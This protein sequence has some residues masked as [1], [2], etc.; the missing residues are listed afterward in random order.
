V[1]L[2][3]ARFGQGA[4]NR[5]G[6]GK[7][8]PGTGEEEGVGC[9]TG[10]VAIGEDVGACARR[11]EGTCAERR[12]VEVKVMRVW[13]QVEGGME[14]ELGVLSSTITRSAFFTV[15]LDTVAFSKY[16]PFNLVLLSR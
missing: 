16:M 4:G 1:S 3:A 14:P 13:H 8:A 9:G 5:C 7:E 6:A 12:T 15:V 11:L 2:C 10:I